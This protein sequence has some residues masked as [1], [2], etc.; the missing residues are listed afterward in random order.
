M[1]VTIFAYSNI[2]V[3]EE[4]S[5]SVLPHA[6]R[7][8]IFQ[9]SARKESLLHILHSIEPLNFKLIIS[10]VSGALSHWTIRS[11]SLR[12]SLRVSL[13][14]SEIE[15]KVFFIVCK[16][17]FASENVFVGAISVREKQAFCFVNFQVDAVLAAT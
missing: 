11:L 9:G 1:L 8:I 12:L 2:G 6:V 10:Y 16:T 14:V 17:Y 7:E 13:K 5:A 15:S 4:F 3:Q